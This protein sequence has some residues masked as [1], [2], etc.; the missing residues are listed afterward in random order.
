MVYPNTYNESVYG[1]PCTRFSTQDARP[2]QHFRNVP[3]NTGRDCTDILCVTETVGP[4][5]PYGQMLRTRHDISRTHC[6][7]TR[8]LS[9]SNERRSEDIYICIY[10]FVFS[11]VKVLFVILLNRYYV[12]LQRLELYCPF[13]TIF[14]KPFRFS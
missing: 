12:G 1:F 7:R 9:P 13:F 2:R 8:R 5:K 10:I 14:S 6:S 4:Y 3:N 11:Y